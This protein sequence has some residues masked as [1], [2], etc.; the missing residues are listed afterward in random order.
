MAPCNLVAPS[1]ARFIKF[2]KSSPAVFPNFLTKS[3]A[4][5]SRSPYSSGTSSSGRPKYALEE[6]E[7]APSKPCSR[8]FA[9]WVADGSKLPRPK[10]SSDEMPFWVPNF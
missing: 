3:L 5:D 8:V 7:V 6:M 2:S 4:A 9:S 1:P 10:N